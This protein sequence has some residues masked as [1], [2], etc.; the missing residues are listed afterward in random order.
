MKLIHTPVRSSNLEENWGSAYVKAKTHAQLKKISRK[1]QR[2]RE[3]QFMRRKVLPA[4]L[5]ELQEMARERQELLAQA[6][7]PKGKHRKHRKHAAF[8]TPV[9]DERFAT[10]MF[11]GRSVKVIYVGNPNQPRED[12]YRVI[13]S[14]ASDRV[15]A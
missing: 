13:A 5:E 8:K 7:A 3:R 1:Q 10:T 6:S 2:A 15:Y 4:C 9:V 14:C 12:D 11:A